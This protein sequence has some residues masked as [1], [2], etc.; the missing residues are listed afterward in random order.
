MTKTKLILADSDEQLDFSDVL[1]AQNISEI[2]SRSLVKTKKKYTYTDRRNTYHEFE[3]IPVMSANMGTTGNIPFVRLAVMSGYFAALEKHIPKEE[4]LDFMDELTLKAMDEGNDVASIRSRVF[5]SIGIKEDIQPLIEVDE[6]FPLYGILFD[7]PNATIPA[8]I[9]RLR[10][11]RTRFP[12][13]YI[14]AKTVSDSE[15]AKLLYDNGADCVGVSVGCG[16]MCLTRQ[17]TGVGRPVFSAIVDCVTNC[18]DKDVLCDGGITCTGDICKALCAGASMVM[19][20]SMFAATREADFGYVIYNDS[21]KTEMKRQYGMS[22]FYAQ[23]TLFNS[24]KS[25]LSY[26]TSEGRTKLIPCSGSFKELD[27]NI[28]G[29]LRSCGTYINAKTVEE[30]P[31]KARFYL[32]RRQLNM[33]YANCNNF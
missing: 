10:E 24:S 30:F 13:T 12:A 28:Q 33:T 17:V 29:A 9:E 3:A 15:H 11:L 18:V 6:K 31:L 7:V 14:I 16:A 19:I 26:R 20:G 27:S 25:E 1:I 4:I 21:S 5:L 32:V 8:A 22:S 23:R 2:N